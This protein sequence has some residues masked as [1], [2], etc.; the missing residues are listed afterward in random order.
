LAKT[1]DDLI[2]RAKTCTGPDGKA[3]FGDSEIGRRLV[4][5]RAETAALRAMTYLAVSRNMRRS[6]PGPDGSMLK[7]L[8]GRLIQEANRIVM[9]LLGTGAVIMTPD[10]ETYLLN[11]ART[12]AGGTDEIQHNI[13]SQRV[14]GLPKHY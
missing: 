1:V 9:E 7:I 10:V 4:R 6:G 12:V 13:V 14:L 3:A 11:F 8:V 5:L 2:D